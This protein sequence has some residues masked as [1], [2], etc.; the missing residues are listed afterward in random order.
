M[1]G[2]VLWTQELGAQDAR[3]IHMNADHAETPAVLADL[4]GDVPPAIRTAL[5]DEDTRP[6]VVPAGAGAMVILRGVNLNEGAV[7]ED[8]IS[9][10]AWLDGERLVTLRKRDLRATDD[11]RATVVSGK[12]PQAPGGVLARLAQRLA[13]RME[14][15]LDLLDDRVAAQEEAVIEQPDPA[16]R[17]DI[18]QTRR[19]AIILRR[20]IAPQREAVRALL[21][22]DLEALGADERRLL[23][24]TGD[25][26]QRH[27]ED[28][29]MLRERA[30]VVKDELANALADRLN[31]NLYVLAVLS[32]V[33][34]PLGFVTGL[35]GVNVAGVPG[36]ETPGAFW[37]MTGAL[38]VGAA[39]LLVL[40]RRMRWL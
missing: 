34:L 25:R 31:R 9:L 32:A 13:E 40:L 20:Y 1:D 19:R 18:A 16:L 15:V 33:F 37:W 6:R 14:P 5:L 4:L 27:V 29:D 28:L 17:R 8:M 36:T 23:I 26:M 11:V 30:Q 12:G 38:A 35:L 3:W 10:R 21:D 24:E 22:A 39:A 2:A 7:P